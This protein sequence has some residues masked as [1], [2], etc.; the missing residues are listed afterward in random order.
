MMFPEDHPQH[1]DVYIRQIKILRLS[2]VLLI[3]SVIYILWFMAVVYPPQQ[4]EG[5]DRLKLYESS[6]GCT[7][8]PP[9]AHTMWPCGFVKERIVGRRRTYRNSN[10]SYY[11]TLRSQN[12]IPHEERMYGYDLWDYARTGD[13]VNVKYWQGAVIHI[14]EDN[15]H[16]DTLRNPE[17]MSTI[18]DLTV[19]VAGL[20]AFWCSLSV[21]EFFWDNRPSNG[22]Y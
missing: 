15:R 13:D 11:I 1:S 17:R 4:R 20:I 6:A 2:L 5:W 22:T 9:T 21:A 10:N 7:T 18:P 3:L 19:W 12:G 14:S 8:V 16:S